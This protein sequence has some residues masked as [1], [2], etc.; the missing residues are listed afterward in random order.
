MKTYA[1]KT[2]GVDHS[3]PIA[4]NGKNV[5][6]NFVKDF[7]ND[8]E[9]W[10][11]TDDTDLQKSIENSRLFKEGEIRLVGSEQLVVGS[12]EEAVSE[13]PKEVGSEQP[14]VNSEETTEEEAPEPEV[15]KVDDA[16]VI[17]PKVIDE[18]TT[19]QQ[20]KDVLS[21]EP[22]KISKNALTKPEYIIKKAAELGVSFPNLVK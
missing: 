9:A 1:M 7:K 2:I 19:F 15:I 18:V 22:Y 11:Y 21:K 3:T 20:A 6:I 5:Y 4:V 17:E 10:F 16:A 12:T 13:E 14:A 8:P